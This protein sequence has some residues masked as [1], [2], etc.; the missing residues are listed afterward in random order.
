MDYV[1]ICLIILVSTILIVEIPIF[2]LKIKQTK[3]T[4]VLSYLF[5]ALI[6]YVIGQ[7]ILLSY[8]GFT[9]VLSLAFLVVAFFSSFKKNKD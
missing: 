5:M 7:F 8:E 9:R 6:V 3:I 4:L 2:L 1:F